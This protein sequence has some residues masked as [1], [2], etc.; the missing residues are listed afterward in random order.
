[1]RFYAGYPLISPE[2]EPLGALCVIDP[3]PRPGGLTELQREGLEVL[4]QA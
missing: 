4:A 3:E 2:G 1:L